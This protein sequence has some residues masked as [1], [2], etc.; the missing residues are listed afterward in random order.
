MKKNY[1]IAKIIVFI[2]FIFLCNY[3]FEERCMQNGRCFYE[4]EFYDLTWPFIATLFIYIVSLF[5]N[6]KVVKKVCF[7][8]ECFFVIYNVAYL[9]HVCRLS[10]G[11]R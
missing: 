8:F 3:I 2:V 1:I 10:N 7:F 5:I 11:C 4:Y 9:I 6:N